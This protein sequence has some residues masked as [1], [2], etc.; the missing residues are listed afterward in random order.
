MSTLI[1]VDDKV[2]NY[3]SLL[4]GLPE[5]AEVLFIDSTDNGVEQIADYLEDREG[6]DALHVISHGSSGNLYLGRDVVD[7]ESMQAQKDVWIKIGQ[8]LN[9]TGDIFLYGCNVAEGEKGETFIQQL[10]EF[11]SADVAAST[12][13]TGSGMPENDWVLEASTG[14][15]ET[16]DSLNILETSWQGSLSWYNTLESVSLSNLITDALTDSIFNFQEVFN[17]LETAVED[18]ITAFEFSDLQTFYDNSISLFSNDYVRYITD[19]VI[20]GNPA[21]AT[22]W[23]GT[24][25]SSSTITIGNLS[26]GSSEYVGESL[27]NEWFEGLDLPMPLDEDGNTYSYGTVT[28]DLFVDGVAASDVNQ[29]YLGDCYF[30]ASM[31]AIAESQPQYIDQ[32]FTENYN[33]TYGVRFF[34][35][36]E[37]IYTT[38]NASI[39]IY[40]SAYNY[41]S[42][43][44]FCGNNSGE[45]SGES[46][47]SLMEK[48]YVQANAQYNLH[49]PSDDMSNDYSVISS[50]SAYVISQITNLEYQDYVSGPGHYSNVF[51]GSD[52]DTS[53][54]KGVLIDALDAGAIVFLDS[55]VDTSRDGKDELVSNHAFMVL[56][57]NSTQD[58]FTIR[59]PWGGNDDDNNQDYWTEF[60]SPIEDFWSSSEY[61][62]WVSISDIPT[63]D[64]APILTGFTPT[65]NATDVEVDSNIT[66]TFSEAVQA[67]TGNILIY[68]D[69][70]TLA[71]SVVVTD[72]QVSFSN[73]T[74]TINPTVDLSSSSSYYVNLAAGVITDMTGNDFAGISGSDTYNFTTIDNAAPILT[75]L[76]PNDNATDV[77]V[78]SNITLTFS[79]AVQAGAGNILIYN[80][81]GTLAR[82]V[83]V[84]DGQVSFSNG[85][86][87]I[88]PTVD[89]SSSSSYY[90]N[91]AA[92]VI[93]DMSGNDFAGISGSDTYNFTTIDNAAPILTSLT[94]T[95]NA[96]DVGVNSN[97][98]LT[99]SE[100]VQAGAGNILIYNDDGTLARSV[101]V[102]DGQ[103]SFSNGTVTINPTVDLSSSSSY[104]VNLAAGVITD[105]TGNDFAG[106]SGSDT[107]NFTTIDNA[108]PI[109]TS[110]TPNDNATDVGVNSNITLTFSEAVQAGTGNIL[111]YNDD[112]TL[113]RSVAVTD[114]Q[115]TFS[116]GTVTINPTVDLSSSSSY[117]VNL[118]AGVITD[119]TGNDFAGISGSDTYNFTTSEGYDIINGTTVNGGDAGDSRTGAT[120]VSLDS[121]GDAS[122]TGYAGEN[123]F[124][125]FVAQHPGTATIDLTGLSSDV[126]LRLLSSSGSRLDSSSSHSSYSGGSSNE[127]VSYNLTSGETYYVKVDPYG[128]NT[129]D[130]NLSINTV[131]AVNDIVN[132]TTISGG[133]AGNSRTGA[134]AVSLDSNGDASITGYA[135]D[136]D[137][138]TFVAQNPGTA[139]INLTGL[140]SDIDL[141]LLNSSGS[142]LDSS[143]SSGSSNESVS[144]NLISG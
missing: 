112:G 134:A 105:M 39:P 50:G 33:G 109:L 113:A 83:A 135:G 64:T 96:T 123:D 106:I 24:S 65:D 46:W 7:I 99:F 56:G 20:N 90:V 103:V 22:W 62:S 34:Y 140:S 88:N 122:I 115:V 141:R 97:I 143:S 14:S 131:A 37:P 93:T 12:N 75:S 73:G 36:G 38:V 130:Y 25:S 19:A 120:A 55:N 94:P 100:E 144:Y 142:R 63:E 118:A 70:G 136:N 52:Y 4:P 16:S 11:S 28:G 101:V 81:D 59:N 66:L 21:N 35:E 82:S 53:T 126:D 72:G 74:V 119:M 9:E 30:V 117:Y 57:Y 138:Y 78:N 91:L 77:G 102:T 48:A 43:F 139:T 10:A 2:E 45:L 111:I 54:F 125:T 110:L 13:S 69:D 114:G 85:T 23:G 128:N 49:L 124:Y 98:T 17:L 67:G 29:G 51:T 80:D 68:N 1:I 132:G 61:K 79:E 89:L 84:T 60:Q 76:T 3:E 71:R 47:A 58:T 31:G 15:I 6:Y 27:I 127:S 32:A 133:D 40:D 8:S 121:N 42:D 95:D 129:S 107:Y 44:V 41:S 137:F 18:G 116:N 86:V 26:T 87:T 92:G 5:D 108:A 104:Y